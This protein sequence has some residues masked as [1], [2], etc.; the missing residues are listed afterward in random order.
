MEELFEY[1]LFLMYSPPKFCTTALGQ[2]PFHSDSKIRERV[3]D[4]RWHMAYADLGLDQKGLTLE[5]TGA[6]RSNIGKIVWAI[7]T[8]LQNPTC[9][10]IR[11]IWGLRLLGSSKKPI[12]RIVSKVVLFTFLPVVEDGEAVVLE[13]RQRINGFVDVRK[14]A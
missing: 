7:P 12:W 8:A 9:A 5:W 4:R 13:R 2:Q 11:R 3:Q 1:L 10:T 6:G 14:S